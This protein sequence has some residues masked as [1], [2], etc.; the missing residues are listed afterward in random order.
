MGNMDRLCGEDERSTL[1][2]IDLHNCQPGRVARRVAKVDAG[3]NLKEVAMPRLP[4]EI[5][6]KLLG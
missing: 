6:V 5:E 2:Q 4:V 1:R 3:C